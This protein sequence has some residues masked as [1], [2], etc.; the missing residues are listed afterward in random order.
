ME[1]TDARVDFA[2]EKGF[3]V[4]ALLFLTDRVSTSTHQVREISE[5]IVSS[6]VN[7]PSSPSRQSGNAIASVPIAPS[8]PNTFR[9]EI[10]QKE[11]MLVI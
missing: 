6:D 7:P 8:S 10:K 5:Y 4:D 9:K 1:D 2:R 3:E 11:I